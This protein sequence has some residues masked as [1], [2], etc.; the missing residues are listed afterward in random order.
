MKKESD[1]TLLFE[2]MP[3]P[4]AVAKLALPTV[5]GS[6]VVILYSLADTFFVGMLNDT[7]QTGAVTLAAPVLL[8]F[9]AVNNL[10]GVGSSSMMSRALGV[11]DLETVKKS[12]AF[13]F[14]C[15]L[16]GG[17][18]IS[19]LCLCFFAPL[20]DL[21]GADNITRDATRN[22]MLWAVI[23]G[24]V[25]SILNV[26]MSNLVRAEGGAMHAG[27]GMMSGCLLNILLDPF[28]ILPGFL[29][30][31]AA[32]AGLATLISNCCACLYY[33]VLLYVRRGKTSVCID[34]RYFTLEKRVVKGVCA[35]GVPAAIQNLLNVTGMTVLNN[36]AAANT[37]A[38]SAIGIA[39]KLTM[40]PMYIAMGTSQGVMPLVGYNYASGNGRRMKDAIL[41]TA[42]I[43]GV[44]MLAM[45]VLY[46]LL[47]GP[48]I[49]AFMQDAEVIRFGTGYI[50]GMSVA[51]PLLGMDFLAVGVFQACGMGRRS[52][53][54]AVLRKV[55]LEIPA[56]IVL[57]AIWPL[58]GLGWAQAFA[59]AVL[60]V[61]A[62]LMLK[63]IFDRTPDASTPVKM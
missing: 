14:W 26:V 62:V 63:R 49:G 29:N 38:V 52:L 21:L 35:V 4:K 48:M 20:L 60:A 23:C 46:I 30:M 56:L 47:A 7:V 58:T 8:A 53:L 40:I 45:M 43:T 9:N 24:A 42:K 22:Y 39:H 57:N 33:F 10:F 59:E 36:F 1:K 51:Q 2:S 25:P 11:K 6:L 12:S 50:V 54:F 19:L 41:F 15:A 44:F 28:F 61:A 31:G 55:V 5:I 37:A 16:A 34:P 3:V 18:L 32:G 13:G 27:I 17:L